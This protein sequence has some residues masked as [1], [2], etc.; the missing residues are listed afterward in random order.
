MSIAGAA[1]AD[2]DTSANTAACPLPEP[3]V[4]TGRFHAGL[5]VGPSQAQG[6]PW[7]VPLAR[8]TFL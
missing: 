8:L 5:P 6:E 1:K 7:S 4:E 3:D 2:A